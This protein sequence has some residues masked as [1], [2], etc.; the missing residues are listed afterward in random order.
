[1]AIVVAAD[2]PHA[3]EQAALALADGQLV[4][5]PTDTVYGIAARLADDAILRLYLAK[6]RPPDKAI[7]ILL[8]SAE[9]VEMVAQPLSPQAKRLTERFWPGPLTLVLPKRDGL[10]QRVSALP[11]V[12][13]RVPDHD[14]ARAVVQAAGGALAVSSANRSGQAPARTAAEVLEQLG[15]MVAVVIDG[16]VCDQEAA[17]TVAALDGRTI[18]VVREGPISEIELQATLEEV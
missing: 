12:G 4:V 9:E 18:R 17:S 7:P 5:F 16:G 11:T 3:I 8:A 2:D 10:P 13:V 14:I 6:E 15:K 1:M